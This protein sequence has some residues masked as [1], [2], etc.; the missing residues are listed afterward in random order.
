MTRTCR[1][2]SSMVTVALAACGARTRPVPV[3][4]P[5]EDVAALAGRWAGEYSSTITGRSGTI[6]FAVAARGDSAAGAI[7]M[8]PAGFAQPLRP[9]RDPSLQTDERT[10]A[11]PS[12]LTIRLV[13]VSGSEVH[14]LLTPYADPRTGDRLFT[15]FDGRLTGD[16]IAGTFVTEPGATAGGVTGRWRVVRQR[17]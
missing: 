11:T 16:T 17:S 8:I 12:L 5:V 13:R 14:G 9:W 7:V 3:V 2:L 15:T 1:L 6:E 10:S 4:G